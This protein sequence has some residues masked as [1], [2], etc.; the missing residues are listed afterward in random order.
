MRPWLIGLFII[1]MAPAAAGQAEAPASSSALIAN[2]GFKDGD[3]GFIVVDRS[4]GRTVVE[5]EADSL[6]IPASVAKLATVYAAEQILGPHER[7]HTRLYR[8]GADLYL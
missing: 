5:R 7:F 4:S 6:F 3:V 8:L 2:L 1:F